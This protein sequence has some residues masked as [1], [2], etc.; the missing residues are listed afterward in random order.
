MRKLNIL[1]VCDIAT[2]QIGGS[3]ISIL[4][5]GGFLKERGHKVIILSAKYPDTKKIDMYNGMK[6]YGLSPSIKIPKFEGSLRF[7]L[8][9]KRKVKKIMEEEKID[10]L[11]IPIPTPLS[12]SAVKCAK[13]LGIKIMAHSHSQPENIFLH[14]PKI[15]HNKKFNDLYYRYIISIYKKTDLLLCPSKFSEEKIKKYDN[16][17]K[18][19]VLS[20][21]VDTSKFKKINYTPLV[22]KYN[23]PISK[24]QVL[25]VGRLS[26]EKSISTLINAI[27]EVKKEFSNVHFNIV[28]GGYVIDELKSLAEKIN[29]NKDVTFYGLVSD[30]E[31]LMAFSLGDIFVLPSIAELEGMVVLE[32]MS[33]GLPIIIANAEESASRYFVQGNGLLFK[34]KD[35]KDLAEKILKLLKNDKLRK[36]MSKVSL[37]NIKEYDIKRSAETLEK[38]CYSLVK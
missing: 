5:F 28:G 35:E 37:K 7:A 11:Y 31:L 4:R 25:Y 19:F 30:K 1:I 12:I 22:K 8:P 26:P 3:F 38:L 33:C 29:I 36:K 34:P 16:S 13:E 17:I 10:L 9:S 24:K 23:V 20:N 14:L 27:P 32:A 6:L 18:T 21:G 2:H 15:F